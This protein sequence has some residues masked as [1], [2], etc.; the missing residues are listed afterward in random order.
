MKSVRNLATIPEGHV[1]REAAF[2]AD[3]SAVGFITTFEGRSWVVGA[4]GNRADYNAAE[5]LAVGPVDGPTAHIARRRGRVERPIHRHVAT[6]RDLVARLGA[7][8]RRRRAHRP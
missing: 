6:T 5:R 2:R 8:G 7:D 4:D 3:G 1:L